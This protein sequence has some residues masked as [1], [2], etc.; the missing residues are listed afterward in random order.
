MAIALDRVSL[1]LFG[2]KRFGRLATL[3]FV[4][5]PLIISTIGLESIL[6][7][8]LLVLSLYCLVASKWFWLAFVLGMLSLTRAEG[9]LFAVVFVFA[10]PTFKTRLQFIG[11]LLLSIAPWY[12][13][14]WIYLGSLIPD[15]LIIR[16]TQ[17]FWQ[18]GSFWNGPA[19]YLAEISGRNTVVICLSATAGRSLAS[20][21][22]EARQSQEL[23]L[24]S[25]AGSLSGI[26]RPG[27]P[28]V[29][30][31]LRPRKPRS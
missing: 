10:I 11:I 13:F 28:A 23:L 4:L 16:V 8:A 3:A 12:L 19:V 9:L 26:F 31:V 21:K 20:D 14:S 22:S 24:A 1:R 18:G 5:N 6:F 2:L 17:T 29:S 27:C 15:S 25:G 7:C 30:L